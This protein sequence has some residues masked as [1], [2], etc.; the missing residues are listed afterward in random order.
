MYTCVCDWAHRL[1]QAHRAHTPTQQ[2]LLYPSPSL[3]KQDRGP[4]PWIYIHT[5]RNIY[6]SLLQLDTDYLPSSCSGRALDGVPL[7]LSPS[8]VIPT[9]SMPLL[10]LW[11]RRDG[12]WWAQQ[13]GPWFLLL[14]QYLQLCQG[15]IQLKRFADFPQGCAW[16]VPDILECV[17]RPS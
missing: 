6:T 3:A 5:V 4:T 8:F 9:A 12:N 10:L 14:P 13:T 17:L 2:Q 16:S 15:Q 1:T 7:P 11:A